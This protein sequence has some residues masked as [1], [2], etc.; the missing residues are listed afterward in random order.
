MKVSNAYSQT[1]FQPVTCL[2]ATG[3]LSKI[4][5]TI[6]PQPSPLPTPGMA[7]YLDFQ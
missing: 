3:K 4:E 5:K 1:F 6:L 7:R 2:V